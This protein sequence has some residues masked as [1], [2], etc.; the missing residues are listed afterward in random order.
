M[1]VVDDSSLLLAAVAAVVALEGYPTIVARDRGEALAQ[2]DLARPWL[3]VTALQMAPMDGGELVVALRERMP[4]LAAVIM[5]PH[6]EARRTIEALP[7]AYLAT[8]FTLGEL[9][10]AIAAATVGAA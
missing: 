9:L 4:G 8:P 1:L 6:P 7:A 3:V 10:W 5:A 2:L